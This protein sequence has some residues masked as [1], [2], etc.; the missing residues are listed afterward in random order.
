MSI[1]L[2]TLLLFSFLLLL[3]VL[4]LPLS[5]C[6]GGVAIVF[7]LWQMGPA[8]LFNLATT[9]VGEWTNFILLAVPLFILMANI[10]ERS[11]IAEDLYEMIYRWMGPLKGGLGM[12]TI[13]ICAV[14]A[15]MSGISAVGTITM[16]LIAL[17][18]MLKRGYDP[19]IAV[20]CISAGG[21]LG[22]LI[23]PSVIMIIYGSMTGSSVGQLFMGGVIPGVLMALI[24]MAYIG[25]RSLIQPQLGPPVPVEER[26]TLKEKFISLYAVLAPLVLIF[27]VLGLLYA[28]VC[29]PTEAA[30][31]GAFG[32]FVVMFVNKKF[33]WKVLHEAVLRTCRLSGMVLWILLG[34]KLFS[35]VYTALGAADLI[36]N[37][38][39]GLE[40]NRW[41]IL[42]GMQLILFFLGCFMDP[43]GIMMICTPIFVPLI[44]KLGFNPIWFGILFTIN[45]ELGYITPPF[46][47]N[48][49]YMK[50]LASPHGV[51]MQDIY[52]SII[53][54][55]FL[56]CLCLAILMAFPEIVLWLPQ[57][58]FTA[59]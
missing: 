28:G 47:F 2:I 53:P 3:L 6:F 41:I 25:I 15:A 36:L 57:K 12:G 39:S 11:G 43:A 5:F 7:I 16:G 40:I 49:F 42:I 54:F 33:S 19:L 14:F 50:A 44:V 30:G 27:L 56:M 18:S 17:P 32:S 23:P 35:S 13:A 52:R 58:M 21:T 59:G 51:S 22:I 45:M 46:G 34:A 9:A 24:F 26:Y 10:L 31:I 8:A 38:F 37:I 20:G 55:V 48:L 1:G 29:T 4:G